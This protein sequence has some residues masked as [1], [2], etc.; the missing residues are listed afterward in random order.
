MEKRLEQFVEISVPERFEKRDGEIYGLLHGEWRLYSLREL[1][2]L[3][4]KIKER[5]EQ[6]K[7]R[8]ELIDIKVIIVDKEKDDEPETLYDFGDGWILEESGID[9]RIVIGIEKV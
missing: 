2:N 9:Y 5:Q 8:N 6:R 1:T 4:N 7:K 3:K